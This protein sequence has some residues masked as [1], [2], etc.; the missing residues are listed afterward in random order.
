MTDKSPSHARV[1]LTTEILAQLDSI[2]AKVDG[3][4][5]NHQPT[6]WGHVGT[7]EKVKADLAEIVRFIGAES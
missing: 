6:N 5:T 4:F 3:D 7:L 2:R 1:R